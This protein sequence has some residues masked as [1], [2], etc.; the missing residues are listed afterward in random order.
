MSKEE[1]LEQKVKKSRL[2]ITDL[3]GIWPAISMGEL[4]KDYDAEILINSKGDYLLT[5]LCGVTNIGN[6]NEITIFD[7]GIYCL[8]CNLSYKSSKFLDLKGKGPRVY[9]M[10]IPNKE[11]L[12]TQTP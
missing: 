8:Q 11:E 4:G 2:E 6:L 12:Q 7:P 5:C 9:T 10:K 3:T 1:D